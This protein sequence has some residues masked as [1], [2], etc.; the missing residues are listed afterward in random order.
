MLI[1]PFTFVLA[2]L[3]LLVGLGGLWLLDYW[4]KEIIFRLT[5]KKLFDSQHQY[6]K[7]LGYPVRPHHHTGIAVKENEL[8]VRFKPGSSL[9]IDLKAKPYTKTFGSLQWYML[10]TRV[11]Q[12]VNDFPGLAQ[13]LFNENDPDI[14][15]SAHNFYSFYNPVGPS[16]TGSSIR[17]GRDGIGSGTGSSISIG[18]DGEAYY[19]LY[20][21]VISRLEFL[22]C[23]S[24][25]DR[26]WVAGGNGQKIIAVLDTGFDPTHE[27]V[28]NLIHRNIVPG[29]SGRYNFID[30]T[31]DVI[32]NQGHGSHILEILQDR[33]S[34][35]EHAGSEYSILPM[36]VMDGNGVGDLSCLIAAVDKAIADGVSIL[37]ISNGYYAPRNLPDNAL[38]RDVM[39]EY[40]SSTNGRVYCSAG[41]ASLE[42][43]PR[44]D[45]F[46]SGLCLDNPKVF[47][48]YASRDNAS[49]FTLGGLSAYRSR[50]LACYSNYRAQ[51]RNGIAASGLGYLYRSDS[52]SFFNSKFTEGTSF[53]VPRVIAS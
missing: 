20:S 6:L 39:R 26:G 10:I 48:V 21:K 43:T 50:D 31:E 5:L 47:E 24:A 13:K 23:K 11:D 51:Y 4:Y 34:S 49:T 27:K 28:K 52:T 30:P 14:E 37:C 12:A 45:H 16:G 15:L 25:F 42:L 2:L 35:H 8:I 29:R 36:K 22:H 33:I 17:I 53:A 19:P 9:Y 3:T 41:N 7:A 32:D 38:I 1:D 44:C 46:P 18:R 40:T